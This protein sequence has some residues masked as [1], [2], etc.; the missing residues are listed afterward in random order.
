MVQPSD[1]QCKQ[2]CWPTLF[3]FW[4]ALRN[5]DLGLG[6]GAGSNTRVHGAGYHCCWM[7]SSRGTSMARPLLPSS[8]RLCDCQL[9]SV[10]QFPFMS[11]QPQRPS[12][13][14]LNPL[15]G[16]ERRSSEGRQHYS[17]D[18]HIS[19]WPVHLLCCWCRQ[20]KGPGAVLCQAGADLGHPL[21]HR[22]HRHVSH[23]SP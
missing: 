1:D 18:C 19:L 9:L 4:P 23:P 15:C 16:N 21:R 11:G 6:P 3:A 14:L 12:D 20:H 13:I 8:V 17:T 7:V 5:F 2:V 22:S 10:I